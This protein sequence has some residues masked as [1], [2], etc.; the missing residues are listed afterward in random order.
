L[1]IQKALILFVLKRCFKEERLVIK[2]SIES[3]VSFKGIVEAKKLALRQGV[4]FKNL[5]RVERGIIDLTVRYVDS[6]KSAKLAKVLTAIIQKLK[7]ATENMTERL[8]RTVGISL[9]KKMSCIAVSWGNVFAS[10]W[11]EDR[12]FARYLAFCLAKT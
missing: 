12:A 3:L 1:R 7:F 8:V 6:V 5:S 9:A 4:W 2:R 10:N 11:A